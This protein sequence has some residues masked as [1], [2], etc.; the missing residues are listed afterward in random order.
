M[1]FIRGVLGIIGVGCAHMAGRALVSVRKGWQK[2]GKLYSWIIRMVVCLA[3]V[4]FRYEIDNVDIL[5]WTLS[6]FALAAGVWAASHYKP[7]EDLTH[8]IFPE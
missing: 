2:P 8:Q 6:A 5:I 3:A 1:E 4:A 7:P